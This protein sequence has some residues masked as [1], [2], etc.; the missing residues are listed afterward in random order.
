MNQ[1]MNKDSVGG[2]V[3]SA[4]KEHKLLSSHILSLC[5]LM[6]WLVSWAVT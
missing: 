1:S 2:I 4:Y 5:E 6:V 3:L